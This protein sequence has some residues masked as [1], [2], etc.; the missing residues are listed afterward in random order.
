MAAL[1]SKFFEPNPRRIFDPDHFSSSS[2][3]DPYGPEVEESKLEKVAQSWAA[4][5]GER[6]EDPTSID[7]GEKESREGERRGSL[8]TKAKDKGFP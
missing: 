7:F 1:R 2:S 4:D 5:R 6:S 3:S 8:R